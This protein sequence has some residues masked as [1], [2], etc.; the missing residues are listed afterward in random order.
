[1]V[2]FHNKIFKHKYYL[3]LFN[4]ILIFCAALAAIIISFFIIVFISYQS[5][6]VFRKYVETI[7]I[8]QDFGFYKLAFN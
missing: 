8:W 2:Q 5:I 3:D 6:P 7:Y 4:K 1:M